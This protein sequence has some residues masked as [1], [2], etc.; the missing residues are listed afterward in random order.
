MV[1]NVC[2][3]VGF[4]GIECAGIGVVMIVGR[5]GKK[6]EMP[7]YIQESKVEEGRHNEKRQKKSKRR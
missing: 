2:R 1:W 4:W 3:S 5:K 6:A 7:S